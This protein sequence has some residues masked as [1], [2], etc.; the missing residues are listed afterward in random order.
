MQ[1]ISYGRTLRQTKKMESL[2]QKV[3]YF[4]DTADYKIALNF[5]KRYSQFLSALLFFLKRTDNERRRGTFLQTL[6]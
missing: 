1:V 5:M 4:V 2:Q 6:I 3:E